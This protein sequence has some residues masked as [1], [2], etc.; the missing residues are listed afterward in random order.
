MAF[1][2]SIL[3]TLVAIALIVAAML[4][5]RRRKPL[6][7]AAGVILVYA[8]WKTVTSAGF[9][10][11]LFFVAGSIAVVGAAV[12]W[13]FHL[14]D[15][16]KKGSSDEPAKLAAGRRGVLG[17]IGVATSPL[18]PTGTAEIDGSRL[19]VS[20]EGEFIAAGSY[21]RVVAKDRK[22]YFV[23]LA[24]PSEVV[25]SMTDTSR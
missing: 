3:L 19:A 24:E 25:E 2:T 12:Y 21:V 15:R 20:T 4:S 10:G 1:F 14:V 23:R 5:K 7:I 13:A 22:Q 16:M 17:R 11:G 18:R 6:L 9:L 8:A